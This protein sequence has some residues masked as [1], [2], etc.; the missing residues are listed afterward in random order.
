MKYFSR[1]IT[2]STRKLPDDG[3]GDA[4]IGVVHMPS[5]TE[6]FTRGWRRSRHGA[7]ADAARLANSLASDPDV[8]IELL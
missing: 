3:P 4:F 7:R 5:G 1:G 2:I 8:P 6:T